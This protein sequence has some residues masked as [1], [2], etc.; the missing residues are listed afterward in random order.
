MLERRSNESGLQRV[1][2]EVDGRAA[3]NCAQ[4]KDA[5]VGGRACIHANKQAQCAHRSDAWASGEVS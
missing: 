3:G 2:G 5:T 1:K 4:V